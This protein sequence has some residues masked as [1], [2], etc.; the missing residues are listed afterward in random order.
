LL[1]ENYFASAATFIEETG[2]KVIFLLS[3]MKW[4]WYLIFPC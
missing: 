1:R 3:F 4:L 2:L